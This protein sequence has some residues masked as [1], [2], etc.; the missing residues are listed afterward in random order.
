MTI[1]KG[2]AQSALVASDYNTTTNAIFLSDGTHWQLLNPLNAAFTSVSTGTAPCPNL[3]AGTSGAQCGNEGTTPTGTNTNVDFWWQNASSHCEDDV[4]NNV[5]VGCAVTVNKTNVYGAFLQDFTS[6]TMEIPEAAGFTA[7]VNSTIGLDTTAN[8]EHTWVNSADAINAVEAAGITA[9]VLTKSTDATHGLI[10]ASSI[11]DDAKNITTAEVISAGNKVFLNG[12]FTD[13]TSGS[14]QLVTGLSYTLPTS[15]AANYS[16]HCALIYDQTSAVVVDQ[17]G[18]G[19][20]GTAPTQL[21]AGATVQLTAGPPSTY[22]SGT[23]LALASTTPTL[24]VS[25]TPGVA[26]TMYR[27]ELDGTIEQPSNATPGVFSIYAFT[28]TG[29]DNL[30]VKRGSYCSLF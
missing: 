22:A 20:T 3:V 8:S 11:T 28:T 1:V 21:N 12:D 16:F 14:L 10:T 2:P 6:G 30:V 19:V 25:F 13:S 15:K 23:L 29:T 18:V 7:T 27:A 26:A 24:V 9:N 17:F 4:E 5:D